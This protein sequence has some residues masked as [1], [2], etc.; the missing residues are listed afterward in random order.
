MSEMRR[1]PPKF[2]HAVAAE[3]SLPMQTS[4]TQNL[5]QTLVQWPIA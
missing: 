5:R 1:Q 2:G 4:I 3:E